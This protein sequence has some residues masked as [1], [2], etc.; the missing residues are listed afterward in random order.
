MII[1][2]S[3]WRTRR[4]I[5]ALGACLTV[6]TGAHAQSTA[7]CLI[8]FKSPQFIPITGGPAQVV[9]DDRCEH[10]FVTNRTANEIEVISLANGTL[11]TPI[12]VGSAPTGL[13]LSPDG[14]TLYVANSG[15]NNL[16]VVDVR[17]GTV[18]QSVLI[19]PGFF[20][21]NS[22]FW[23][24]VAKTGLVLFSAGPAGISAGPMMQYDPA[25]GTVTERQDFGVTEEGTYLRAS[26]DRSVIGVG[27]GGLDVGPVYTYSASTNTFSAQKVLATGLSFIALD[28][29]GDRLL[30]DPGT[31]VLDSNLNSARSRVPV[32]TIITG[33]LLWIRAVLSAIECQ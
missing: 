21:N 3:Q 14:S 30:V 20:G 16:S 10:A 31:F 23:L 7:P 4:A 27:E 24:A 6:W 25:T 9:I 5:A 33:E 12:A 2:S 32:I 18:T 13:D 26:S 8:A 29:A 22:P 28:R 17:T 1:C 11:G 19:P 15:G